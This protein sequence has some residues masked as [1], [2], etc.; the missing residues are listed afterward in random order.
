MSLENLMVSIKNS[1]KP[2]RNIK[3]RLRINLDSGR[4][5]RIQPASLSPRRTV[6]TPSD[7][8]SKYSIPRRRPRVIHGRFLFDNVGKGT[9]VATPCVAV[10]SRFSNFV[11]AGTA[12]RVVVPACSMDGFSSTTRLREPA[13]LHPASRCRLSSPTLCERVQHPASLKPRRSSLLLHVNAG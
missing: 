12:S 11:R 7:H 13:L 4:D 2:F 6:V 1:K 3:V 5:D 10:S 9:C 8:A